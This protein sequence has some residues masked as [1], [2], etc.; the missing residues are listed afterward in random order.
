MYVVHCAEFVAGACVSGP[1]YN[2]CLHRILPTPDALSSKTASL[3]Q[4]RLA[5]RISSTLN[6]ET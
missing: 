2:V 4:A 6:H 1:M 3:A 5:S